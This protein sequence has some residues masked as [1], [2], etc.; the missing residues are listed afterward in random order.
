M[1][2]TRNELCFYVFWGRWRK[3]LCLATGADSCS[4]TQLLSLSCAA[5]SVIPAGEDETPAARLR[6]NTLYTQEVHC[7]LTQAL[8][9]L[10]KDNENALR[11]AFPQPFV[12]LILLLYTL[13]PCQVQPTVFNRFEVLLLN[14]KSWGKMATYSDFYNIQ[15]HVISTFLNTFYISVVL[16]L[17]F[18][19]RTTTDWLE[20]KN[21]WR[22]CS[23]TL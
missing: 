5:D 23:I 14:Q 20:N 13:T 15:L 3:L 16:S 2:Q 12:A 6:G 18:F 19:S 22:A 10:L 9:Y 11:I 8:I 7:R 4:P 17:F 1:L 21:C